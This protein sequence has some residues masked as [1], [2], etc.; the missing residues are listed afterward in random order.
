MPKI[1]KTLVRELVFGNVRMPMN[2][3]ELNKNLFLN[4]DSQIYQYII[5][6]VFLNEKKFKLNDVLQ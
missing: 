5:A 2:D 1:V 6:A 3:L 4:G